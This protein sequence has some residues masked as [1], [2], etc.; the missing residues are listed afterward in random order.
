MESFSLNTN[1]IYHPFNVSQTA[2]RC[3]SRKLNTFCIFAGVGGRSVSVAE[4]RADV[5]G[6]EED[7]VLVDISDSSKPESLG[8][9]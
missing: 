6:G 1:P 3:P 5:E 4:A 9:G 2:I 7:V 8:G